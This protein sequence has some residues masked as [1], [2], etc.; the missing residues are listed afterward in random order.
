[1]T[2]DGDPPAIA[3]TEDLDEGPGDAARAA[4]AACIER[5]LEGSREA[6]RDLIERHRPFVYNLALKMFGQRDDA[7]DL[8]QEVFIKAITSLATFRHASAFRTWLYRIT[9]NHFLKTRRRGMELAVG[10]FESYF[11]QVAQVP[12]EEPPLLGPSD[13]TTEELRLRC[14]T[15]M[16]MCLDREQRVTFILGAMFGVSH[17]LGGEL[18]NTTPGNFRVRLFR[19]RRDLYSWMHQRCGLVN[20]ANPCR[21]QKKTA[22]YIKL[23]LVDPARL[24]FNTDY[25][26]RVEAL[27]RNRATEAMATMEALHERW[28]T[29]HPLQLSA[30]QLTE[31]ILGHE[32]LRDF[33][34][35]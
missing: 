16:L 23:G 6:L 13:E 35:V 12:M 19:A 28:F 20:E 11:D 21:C 32:T 29:N 34:A 2:R 10:D 3:A 22:G 4:D 18:L 7:E 25:V 26:V 14:T 17:R 8:T 1:M 27:T 24:V 9:V 15:G 5:A 30:S 31:Q 33:F